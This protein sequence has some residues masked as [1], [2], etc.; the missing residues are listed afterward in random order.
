LKGQSPQRA[1]VS[2]EEEKVFIHLTP[3]LKTLAN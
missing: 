1:V 2:T 3:T